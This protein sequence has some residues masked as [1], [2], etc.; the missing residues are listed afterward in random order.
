MNSVAKG[1]LALSLSIGLCAGVQAQSLP[2]AAGQKVE[3]AKETGKTTAATAESTK[4][5]A[6]D[7]AAAAKDKGKSAVET[8][9]NAATYAKA[10]LTK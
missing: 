9:K 3:K 7:S 5:S 8:T 4:K 6:T 10:K 2:G 1:F